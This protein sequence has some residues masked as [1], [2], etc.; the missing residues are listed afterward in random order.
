M[1]VPKSP[2]KVLDEMPPAQKPE[3]DSTWIGGY[4]AW[5]DDRKDFLWVSGIW[6][7][8]PPGKSWVAGYWRDGNEQWQWVPGFWA[9]NAKQ[10]V[11]QVS[12]LPAPPPP[13]HVAPPGNPP[14]A[15]SFYVPGTWV[16][17]GGR[18]AWQAGYWANVQPGYVWVASHYQWTPGG[19]VYVPGYWDI[20]LERRGV[21]FAPVVVDAQVVPVGFV[22][23]PAYVVHGTVVVDSLFVR[24]AYG[25]YY[26]GDY[27]GPAY[28]QLGFE[29]YV[30]YGRRHYDSIYVYSRWEN[31][32]DPRWETT[33]IDITLA[34]HSGRAPLPPRT[35]VQQNTIIQQNITNVNVV[36]NTTNVYQNTAIQKSPMVVPVSQMSAVTKANT[37]PLAPAARQEARQQAQ[38][39]QQ[40]V[41]QR[42]QTEK[43]APA[44]APVQ[45]RVAT[46]KVPPA[47]PVQA[48]ATPVRTGQSSSPART[49]IAGQPSTSG[50]PATASPVHTGSAPAKPSNPV[51]P[52]LP[53][54]PKVATPTSTGPQPAQ[55]SNTLGPSKSIAPGSPVTGPSV[56]KPSA[57]NPPMVR[58]IIGSPAQSQPG[59]PPGLNPTTRPPGT[60]PPNGQQRP[61]PRPAPNNRENP[62]KQPSGT[63]KSGPCS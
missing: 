31:R 9:E 40:V 24:P 26:F 54:A 61:Q 22:Y 48:A 56:A 27:Y 7:T 59:R 42:V 6:R 32:H 23:T 17:T 47:A 5:D 50:S 52:A 28:R 41:A 2:P 53:P 43:P 4:W 25:H 37:V 8:P 1:A 34:R 3:G 39:T 35:L 29:S 12:Y 19:C 49:T 30:V 45:P 20:A 18:Y 14:S 63:D 36:K 15:E 33:Q 51:S 11:Q 62:P 38:A 55:L 58:P 44:G 57:L 13:P 21:L 16:W 46:L 60:N 10:N